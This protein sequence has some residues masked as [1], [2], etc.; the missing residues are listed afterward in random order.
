MGNLY[1]EPFLKNRLYTM[2]TKCV[3][4]GSIGG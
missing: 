4:T 3:I 2:L 1:Y